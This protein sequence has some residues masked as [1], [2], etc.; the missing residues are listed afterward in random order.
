MKPTYFT[1]RRGR[2]IILLFLLFISMLA[3]ALHTALPTRGPVALTIGTTH[4]TLDFLPDLKLHHLPGARFYSYGFTLHYR[5]A[6]LQQTQFGITQ[7]GCIRFI[8]VNQHP[9]PFRAAARCVPFPGTYWNGYDLPLTIDL[10]PYLQQGD[11][12]VQIVTLRPEFN[13]GP[14][15]LTDAAHPATWLALALAMILTACMALVTLAGDRA[16]GLL[17]AGAF[18][19]HMNRLSHSGV[20]QYSMDLPGHLQYI[21][22][23][24]SHWALPNPFAGWSFYHAPLYYI[25]GAVVVHAANLSDFDALTCL[26]LFSL[27][28][29][30]VFILYA[31][32]ILERLI[33]HRPARYAA[34]ALLL[35]YPGGILFSARIDSNL[36]YY[37]CAAG[38]L[39]AM[40]RWLE[41]NDPRRLA[42]SL[43]W[44]GLALATRSN[45]LILLPILLLAAFYHR[46]RFSLL[47][48]PAQAGIQQSRDQRRKG[49]L[50]SLP[51][52]VPDPRL[53]GDDKER[54][55]LYA[56]LFLVLLGLAANLGRTEYYRLAEHHSAPFIVA[57]STMLSPRV[58]LPPANFGKMLLPDLPAYVQR[59]FWNV[60]NDADG[61][62]SF[63]NSML[64]SSL[65][66]EFDWPNPTLALAMGDLLL[67]LIAF[68]ADGYILHRRTLRRSP[69]W[70]MCLMTLAVWIA[71]LME[72]RII[73]P[74]GSS[75]DFRYIYP[76]LIS[77]CGLFGL[78][79]EQHSLTKRPFRKWLGITLVTAFSACSVVFYWM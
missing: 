30:M 5:D 27:G 7:A 67:A 8:L 60:W 59:P 61:R 72:N 1:I 40:L 33:A 53:R 11:N 34:L 10:K 58:H 51:R 66:G 24:A 75:E 57:N 55:Y 19:I 46:D 3:A 38:C 35:F 28:C 13:I 52:V 78:A 22:Y 26:Q 71:A 39:H 42:A 29:F 21:T 65:T 36:L 31:A 17:I 68:T 14:L 25:L 47:V 48:I 41:S 45:A 12:D 6:A 49:L 56:A 74:Y 15:I 37:T 62:Q 44:F 43:A 79:L 64:K 18:L 77:F 54:T 20:S 16:A 69:K 76:A 50:S 23:I 4:Q 32:R 2:T 63:W 70:W 9:V 73:N